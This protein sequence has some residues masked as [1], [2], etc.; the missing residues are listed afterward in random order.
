MFDKYLLS[1][2]GVN[3]EA[4]KDR[5]DRHILSELTGAMRINLN[6]GRANATI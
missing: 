4:L 3:P 5:S 1:R 6:N 2:L